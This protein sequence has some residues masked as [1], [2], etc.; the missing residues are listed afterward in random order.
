M[1]QDR[2]DVVA[3]ARRAAVQVAAARVQL[4]LSVGIIGWWRAFAAPAALL[5]E[6]ELDVVD[7]YRPAGAACT[8][9]KV[10]EH[11]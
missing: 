5:D 2:R 10:L 7:R 1:R 9:E 3:L 4:R 8:V 6:V 11:A